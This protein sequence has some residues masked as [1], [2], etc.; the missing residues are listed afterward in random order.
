MRWI[1]RMLLFWLLTAPLSYVFGLP[2]L[3]DK[4]TANVRQEATAQCAD[5]LTQ[6]G[7]MGSLNSPLSAN[8]G[9]VYCRCI[10][11]GLIFTKNDL[12][13][14]IQKKQPAALNGLVQAM[15]DQCKGLLQPAASVTPP[16][17]QPPEDSSNVIYF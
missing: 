16:P 6:N 7:M 1:G 3:L 12:W 2:L 5:Q 15:T 9:S 14:S 8:Q 4:L 10:S 17:N 11:D 13:D